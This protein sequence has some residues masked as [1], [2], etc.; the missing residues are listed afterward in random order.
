MMI[1]FDKGSAMMSRRWKGVKEAGRFHVD[2]ARLQNIKPDQV[3]TEK[4]LGL[5]RM[6]HCD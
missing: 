3:K 5:D 2:L 1:G 6:L 4:V